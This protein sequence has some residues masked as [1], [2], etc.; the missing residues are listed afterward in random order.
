M[1]SQRDESGDWDGTPQ[2]GFLA[3]LTGRRAGLA[4]LVLFAAYLVPIGV[5]WAGGTAGGRHLLGDSSGLVG[6]L[7]VV[8]GMALVVALTLKFGGWF[9]QLDFGE[10][11][12]LT[13]RP[14]AGYALGWWRTLMQFGSLVLVTLVAADAEDAAE[15]ARVTNAE[16]KALVSYAER[17]PI[18]PDWE[19]HTDS[20]DQSEYREGPNATYRSQYAVPATI[21]VADLEAWL[22]DPRWRRGT[23][24]KPPVGALQDISCDTATATCE[25]AVAPRSGQPVEYTVSVRLMDGFTVVLDDSSPGALLSYEL[26]YEKAT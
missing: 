11:Y 25:A 23:G 13:F 4:A 21:T 9:A 22:R 3:D 8:L 12:M 7:S 19:L 6:L 18:P 24:T 1:P 14:V 16:T 26:E 5:A 10:E 20:L 15:L 2:P 17:A